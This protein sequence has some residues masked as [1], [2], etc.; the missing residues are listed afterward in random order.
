ME[1]PINSTIS[2]SDGTTAT[3]QR[4]LGSGAQGIVY[5]VSANN[6]KQY[7]LKCYHPREMTSEF[8]ENLKREIIPTRPPSDA[9][10]WPKAIASYNGRQCGYIM[11][12][13]PK[14]FYELSDYFIGSRK[15]EA[16]FPSFSVRL[17][18]ALHICN[19]YMH[20]HRD[21]LCYQDIN[22]GSFLIR[23]SDGQVYI[24]DLST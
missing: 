1:I 10:L 17:Q 19:A 24:C 5:L 11:D 7:A 18:A 21:G 22:A 9:F 2:L 20:L 3:I 12:L 4:E 15:P 13:A 23:P 14:D 16:E 8:Y 6:G